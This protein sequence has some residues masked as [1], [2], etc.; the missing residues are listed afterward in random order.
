M[1]I[2]ENYGIIFAPGVIIEDVEVAVHGGTHGKSH[3]F[4]HAEGRGSVRE[5]SDRFSILNPE[6]AQKGLFTRFR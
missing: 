2:E 5:K 6:Q 1:E 3:H 4:A